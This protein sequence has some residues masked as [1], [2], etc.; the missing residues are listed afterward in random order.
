MKVTSVDRL[1]WGRPGKGP[2]RTSSAPQMW[3]GWRR[4]GL[5]KAFTSQR[6][7][8]NGRWLGLQPPLSALLKTLEEPRTLSSFTVAAGR[9]G[10]G[11]GETG[12][13]PPELSLP[14]NHSWAI[15]LVGS[16]TPHRIPGLAVITL[17][18]CS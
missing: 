7:H 12:V 1:E 13:D 11:S 3:K 14:S 9:Q 10:P 2:I 8:P 5:T 18:F 4:G 16:L 17:A 6:G 15:T